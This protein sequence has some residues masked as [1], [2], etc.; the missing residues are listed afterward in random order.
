MA[1]YENVIVIDII[2]QKAEKNMTDFFRLLYAL[3]AD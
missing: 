2:S 3:I 1:A